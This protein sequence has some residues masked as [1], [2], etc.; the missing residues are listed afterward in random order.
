MRRAAEGGGR[1]NPAARAL[2]TVWRALV[3]RGAAGWPRDLWFFWRELERRGL[4]GTVDRPARGEPP[5]AADRA[6]ARIRRLLPAHRP[7]G[8]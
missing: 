3:R 8:P 4:V 6:V 5:G 1:T 7:P 2:G